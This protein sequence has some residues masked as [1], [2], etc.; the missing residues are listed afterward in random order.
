MPWR[1]IDLE[2]YDLEPISFLFVLSDLAC[3]F[4]S[5]SRVFFFCCVVTHFLVPSCFLLFHCAHTYIYPSLSLSLSRAVSVALVLIFFLILAIANEPFSLSLL[6]SNNLL[7]NMCLLLI[8]S[9]MLKC[10]DISTIL[11]V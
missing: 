3:N 10:T 1:M 7:P 6:S 11:F 5:L 4:F 2:D 9:L 8:Q